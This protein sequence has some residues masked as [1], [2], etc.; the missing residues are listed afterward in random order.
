MYVSSHALMV[1][2]VIVPALT[3]PQCLPKLAPAGG[4]VPG[5][6]PRDAAPALP[7]GLAQRPQVRCVPAFAHMQLCIYAAMFQVATWI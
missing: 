1:Q 2:G 4:H 7:P 3:Q 5:N 6:G